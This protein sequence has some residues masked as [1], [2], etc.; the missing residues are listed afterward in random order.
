MVVDLVEAGGGSGGAGEPPGPYGTNGGQVVL[1]F[2]SLLLDLLQPQV[3][4]VEVDKNPSN[5]QYQVLLVV[6]VVVQFPQILVPLS[7]GRP[8]W[9]WWTRNW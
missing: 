7:G 9:S 8:D 6:A 4:L 1:V 3:V 5:N 2:R